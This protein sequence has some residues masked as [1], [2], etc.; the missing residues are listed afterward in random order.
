[1]IT[2]TSYTQSPQ[3]QFTEA[4]ILDR[5]TD[6]FGQ[7]FS[8]PTR[9]PQISH[10]MNNLT[11]VLWVKPV[12]NGDLNKLTFQRSTNGGESFGDAINVTSENA[13][14][15]Q[16][17]SRDGFN[18]IPKLISSNDT[19]YIAFVNLTDYFLTNLY[20]YPPQVAVYT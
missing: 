5:K 1:L 19:V 16:L 6:I 7:S 2:N 15:F 20:E 9:F 17:D 13:D 14:L 11:S 4:V 8:G 3:E 18:Y 12:E 10:S